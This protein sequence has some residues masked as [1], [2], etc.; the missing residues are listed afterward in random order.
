MLTIAELT[1]RH[2]H[3]GRVEWIGLRTA[4]RG[5]IEEVGKA[6]IERE[7]LVGD[8]RRKPGIRAVSLIQFE[9][10][11]VI[12]ALSGAAEVRFAMLR[13]NIAVARLN[14]AGLKGRRFRI[15]TA[16]LEGTGACTPCSRMEA[17]L[18]HGGYAAVRHHGGLLAEVVERRTIEM[19]AGSARARRG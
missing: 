13:R 6:R 15:G 8:H 18:G 5:E 19:S 7:G 11:P 12:A 10:L 16:V 14:L 1:A 3:E 2:A 4:R 9:H 17:A